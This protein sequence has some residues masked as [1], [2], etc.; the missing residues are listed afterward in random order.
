MT[1]ALVGCGLSSVLC[2]PRSSG[3][4]RTNWSKGTHAPLSVAA[5]SC[6][7]RSRC[8]VALVRPLSRCL[9][10][11]SGSRA[12]ACC[13]APRSARTWPREW[14]VARSF[15]QDTTRAV[16]T[17]TVR[18]HCEILEQ[19]VRVADMTVTYGCL[20]WIT[21]TVIGRTQPRAICR[22]CVSGATV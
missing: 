17:S 3:S 1:A 10:N 7:D 6:L 15:T 12:A 4:Q 2:A 22:F 14:K 21:S 9:R 20:M 11:E 5:S 18:G 8:L 19:S 13:S 16:R